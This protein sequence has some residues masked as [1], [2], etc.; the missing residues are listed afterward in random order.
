M[1]GQFLTDR[2]Q[3]RSH[4]EDAGGLFYNQ[5]GQLLAIIADGMGGHQAGDVASQMATKTLEEKW[6]QTT[7]LDTP[8]ETE[9]WLTNV[10]EEA[11]S[12]IYQ[13]SLEKDECQGMGTTIVVVICNEE[14]IT[15]AH[16]G[17]SRCYIQNSHGFKQITED[18]SLVN[19]LVQSGQISKVD[20]QLHPRK[21]VVLKA[22]GTEE[23]V[24][25]DIQTL[26]WEEGDKLLLCSDGLSDKV[27]EEELSEYIK[28]IESIENT[29]EKLI[30]LANQRGGEDN[31][32]LVIVQHELAEKVGED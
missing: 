31:V 21:N 18:H 1:I 24:E 22:L 10:L 13:Q 9:N 20:A 11:N 19:A 32:S 14:F 5:S 25:S 8:E 6:M 17:D 3:V 26:G 30:T 7:T 29:G 23:K 4:N 2:G 27:M 15:V 12:S 28:T 16:I